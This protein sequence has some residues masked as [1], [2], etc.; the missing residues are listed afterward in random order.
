MVR[1]RCPFE[2]HVLSERHCTH[3]PSTCRMCCT[4]HVC[5]HW[6][7]HGHVPEL[8]RNAAPLTRADGVHGDCVP[9]VRQRLPC[10]RRV[11]EPPVH[12]RAH[13]RGCHHRCLERHWLCCW[14]RLRPAQPSLA[15][16]TT[17]RCGCCCECVLERPAQHSPPSCPDL[18]C[19]SPPTPTLLLQYADGAMV[20]ANP[21]AGP[22][23]AAGDDQL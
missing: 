12:H 7:S 11:S 20:Q 21:L 1:C 14:H 5:L 17:C 16:G 18:T 8:T 23:L 6:H 15:Q 9:Y 13:S 2:L 22:V 3:R 4:V 19:L 10:A